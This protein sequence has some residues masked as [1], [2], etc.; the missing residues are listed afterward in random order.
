MNGIVVSGDVSLFYRKLGKPGATPVLLV[1]GLSYFSYDWLPV[2]Q[3]LSK[4]RAGAVD[5]EVV[6]M[7]MRGFGDSTWSAARDYSVPTMARDIVN[8]LDHLGWPRAILSGH[9]MG[10]R[11]TTFVAAKHPAR[12]AGLVLVDF[13]PENAAAGAKRV[14]QI[15]AGTPERFAS[16][17]DALAYFGKSDRVRFENYLKKE[18]DGFVIKRDTHFRDLFRKLLD[19]GER[20]KLGVDMWQL[21]GEVRCPILSVRGARS[22]MYAPESVAKMKAANPRLSV[23]E[24][25]AGHDIGG[26]N[27][28]GYL[29]AVR[30]FL[31]VLEEEE[32]NH[33]NERG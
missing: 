5:R 21:I 32:K 8:L 25:D 3:A 12:V 29:A 7:D 6:A 17:D 19:T 23:V 30:P 13:T 14:T 4:D 9:S 24:V 18:K 10:G 1:H 31:K 22:D 28:N 20:P 15:V 27:P 11:S 16:V 26:E 2:A 33:A